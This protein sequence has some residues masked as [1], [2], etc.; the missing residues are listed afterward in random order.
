MPEGFQVFPDEMGES[1]KKMLETGE[2]LSGDI[3]KF[4]SETDALTS[5][6]GDDDLGS[7]IAEIYGVASEAAFESFE[8]NAEGVNTAG[9]EVQGMAKDYGEIDAAN[10][11]SFQQVNGGTK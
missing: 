4:R 1:G 8:S 5:G 9:Q 6:F 3:E 2:S 7:A 11:D 10:N